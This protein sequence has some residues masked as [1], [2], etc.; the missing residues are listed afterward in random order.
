MS[1]KRR[2]QL[3]ELGIT[4]PTSTLL[5]K[6][7]KRKG[8]PADTGPD[9]HTVELVLQRDAYQC[10]ICADPLHGLRGVDYSLHHRKLRS[11]GVDHRASNLISLCGNGTAGCHGAVHAEPAK[12]RRGGWML[13]GTDDPSAV[14]VLHVLHGR[15]LLG[16]DGS[17]TK[18]EAVAA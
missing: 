9:A 10:V 18:V 2:A 6:P 15:V 1:A 7:S 8:K 11:A 13:R 12:A 3:A 17:V 14:P 4:Y 16:V 5:P